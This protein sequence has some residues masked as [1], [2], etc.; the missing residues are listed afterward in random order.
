MTTTWRDVRN[1]VGI[2]LLFL[3][4][5]LA[6]CLWVSGDARSSP[7]D[8]EGL[9]N[10][11]QRNYCRALTKREPAYCEVIKDQAIRAT[12]RAMVRK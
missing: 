4:I 10:A 8:C 6:A 2:I 3:A 7:L 11:D 1:V 9:H 5:V 12:C